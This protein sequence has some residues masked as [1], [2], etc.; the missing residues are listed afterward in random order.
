MEIHSADWAVTL[1]QLIDFL[2]AC[3]GTERHNLLKEKSGRVNV[4]DVNDNFICAWTAEACCSIALLLNHNGLQAKIMCSHAW[5][6]DNE[7]LQD[8]LEAFTKKKLLSKDVA[9]WLCTLALY[10]PRK[11]FPDAPG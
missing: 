3:R 9:I 6:E 1:Q 8:A 7:E 4:Y 5:G 10:Q 2:T 11:S